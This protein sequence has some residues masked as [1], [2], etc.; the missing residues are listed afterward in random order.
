M[1]DRK[2]PTRLTLE[3]YDSKIVWEVPYSDVDGTELVH[4]FV[5]TML[6]A[7]FSLQTIYESMAAYLDDHG[8]FD[9]G[10]PIECE[11]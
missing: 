9:C 5:T 2:Q 1:D 7:T 3:N 4:A 8:Y 6:G 11:D 10:E